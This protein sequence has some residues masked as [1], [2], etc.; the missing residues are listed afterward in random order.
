MVF[1][2]SYSPPS[3]SPPPPFSHDKAK[4]V[5]GL[6]GGDAEAGEGLRRTASKVASAVARTVAGE[7]DPT[8]AQVE[9]IIARSYAVPVHPF[10][11]PRLFQSS[12]L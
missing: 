1:H 10:Y 9:A 4:L 2:N 11:S 3:P 8:P 6:L 12:L 7:F 5:D